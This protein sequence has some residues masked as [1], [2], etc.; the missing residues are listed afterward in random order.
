MV[1]EIGDA[2]PN[3]KKMFSFSVDHQMQ[4]HLNSRTVQMIAIGGSIGTGLFVTIG[5][6]LAKAG[7]GGLLISF[8]FWTLVVLLLTC[9]I[10]E[11]VCYL[12]VTSAFC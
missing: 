2:T 6:G 4:R 9:N 11:M 5:S 7:P 10:G 12:P 1:E 3:Q 8:V